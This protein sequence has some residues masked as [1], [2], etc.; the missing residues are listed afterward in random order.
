LAGEG[1]EVGRL[2]EVLRQFCEVLGAVGFRRSHFNEV[3]DGFTNKS[4]I[5]ELQTNQQSVNAN[6]G[7]F[8]DTLS[9]LL[10]A[11]SRSFCRRAYFWTY[12][13]QSIAEFCVF[14]GG[15]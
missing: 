6:C 7:N 12:F 3:I 9:S 10:V 2:G 1:K 15:S 8:D 11:G 13:C 14:G 5:L 4:E